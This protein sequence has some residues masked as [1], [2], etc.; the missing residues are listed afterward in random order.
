MHQMDMLTEIMI[1]QQKAER[2]AQVERRYLV[3]MA[4]EQNHVSLYRPLLAGLGRRLVK[5]GTQLQRHNDP[6]FPVREVSFA[7]SSK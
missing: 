1:K 4:Q 3:R 7:R 2:E 6:C 5:W